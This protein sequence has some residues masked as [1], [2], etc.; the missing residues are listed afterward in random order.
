MAITL[1]YTDYM[2]IVC[3]EREMARRSGNESPYAF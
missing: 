2:I 3:D 1:F